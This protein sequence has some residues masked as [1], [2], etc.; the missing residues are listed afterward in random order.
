MR[1]EKIKMKALRIFGVTAIAV[2]IGL[3][4]LFTLGGMAVHA[5]N[6]QLT[7]TLEPK[8]PAGYVAG[9]AGIT[10]LPLQAT[11]TKDGVP[12][13][14]VKVQFVVTG[15]NPQTV[16]ATTD[17]NG[18][19]RFTYTGQAVGVDTITA[20]ANRT[21]D[22]G[23]MEWGKV[24]SA[25]SPLTWSDFR[26]GTPPA[27]TNY[28]AVTG[29]TF[30]VAQYKE[31]V[32]KP[33][34][35]GP[36]DFTAKARLKNVKCRAS[37]SPKDSWSKAGQQTAALLNHEQGHFN[38]AEVSAREL[39]RDLKAIEV[40]GQGPDP[41]AAHN[42][43]LAKL[44]AKKKEV[45]AAAWAANDQRQ[46]QYDDETKNGTIPTKQAEWDQKIQNLLNALPQSQ[47]FSALPLVTALEA[48]AVNAADEI[49]WDYD[50]DGLWN[51]EELTFNTDPLNSDTDY[52]LLIDGEE[53]FH[54]G[55]DPTKSDTDGDG[56]LDYIKILFLAADPPIPERPV[57]GI[58][59]PA[60]KLALLAPYIILAA[61]IAIVAVSVAV[62]MRRYR[63]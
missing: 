27:Q 15:A 32:D 17:A 43:A 10:S 47:S 41:V 26:W 29:Y 54:F 13:T 12:Q 31:E 21:Q 35:R 14:G 56:V 49:D 7:I 59:F 23:S 6:Q 24:W 9:Y 34:E 60:D 40:T 42:D 8:S 19:A 16:T 44:R 46:K 51:E 37:F 48:Y 3:S 53:V 11:V 39:C 38:L 18:K 62:Y 63:S 52:D 61:L 1:E 30:S 22:S 45:R 58:A 36:H 55:T 5:D 33:V 28:A 50:S 2:A 4:L 20:T 57:G 25:T